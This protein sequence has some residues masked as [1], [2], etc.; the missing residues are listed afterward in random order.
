M[1]A[2]ETDLPLYEPQRPDPSVQFNVRLPKSLKDSLEAVVEL[3]IA[4]AKSRGDEHKHIDLGYVTRRMLKVGV[5]TAFDEFGGIPTSKD[6]WTKVHAAIEKSAKS[7][8]R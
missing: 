5:D 1:L 6:D 7:A 3:W 2:Q 4:L 8:K